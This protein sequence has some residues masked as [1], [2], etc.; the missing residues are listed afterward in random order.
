MRA[1]HRR[2]HTRGMSEIRVNGV[3]LYYEERGAG[4]PIVGVHGG[5]SSAAMWV[6]AALELAKYGRTILYDRRG[7]FRSEWPK[8]YATNVHEQA[9]DAAALI[10][11]LAAAPA[12]VI[13][14]SYGGAIAV[15]LALRYPDR[16][17]ALVLLEGD[18]PSVSE[19]AARE[20]AE[21]EE[22][23]LAE[24]DPR[25]A[26]E[27]LMR[28]VLGDAG[29][30]GVPEEV[31]E[32]LTGNG[33]ALVAEIRGGYPDVTVDQL[34]TIAQPTLFVGAKGSVFDYRETA[35]V[36]A[37]ALPSARVEWVEGG[38]AIDPAHP[39]VLAFIEEVLTLKEEPSI[40]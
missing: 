38:H 4:E 15:D 18:V 12:I 1:A 6:E 8:P 34:G 35:E 26:A 9:D 7:S 14:R 32:I 3:S 40:A 2:S 30:A 27:A 5:G 11:A 33:P 17:R 39:V 36:L 19:T 13:G 29:W 24:R 23:L 16:V 31:K 21:I 20:W 22:R 37:A 28:S 10:D 25:R